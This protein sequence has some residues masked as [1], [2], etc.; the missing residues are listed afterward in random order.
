MAVNLSPVAGAAAQFFDNS[1]QVLTGGKLYTYDAGTTTPAPTYTSSSGV[2]AQPNP[3][4]LNAAGRVPDS[5]E[6]WLSDSVSYKFVLKDANDVLIGTYD[7][8]VG[9]NS[10][11]V[12]FT[13]EEETQT[14]TQGQT[15]FTLATLTYQPATNNLLVFV[16]GS[17]QVIGTNFIETSS[18]VITFIDG[19]NV[20]DIVDFCTATPINTSVMTAAQVS[21]NEGGAGAVTRTVQSKLQ[22]SVSV[23]DF[24]AICDGTTDDTVAVQKA[25]TY[26]VTNNTNLVVPGTCLLTA[27]ININRAVDVPNTYFYISGVAG[28]TTQAGFKTNTAINLFSSTL[29]PVANAPV[30][31]MIVFKDLAIQSS[32]SS[33]AAYV[34]AGNKFLRTK[35]ENC[36]FNGIKCLTTTNYVQSIYFFNCTMRIFSGIFFNCTSTC[37][38]VKFMGNLVENGGQC[39]LLGSSTANQ[40]PNGCCFIGNTIEGMTGSAIQYGSAA[41]LSIIG[42]YF[43][44]NGKDIDGATIGGT[45]RGIAITGNFYSHGPYSDYGVMWGTCS[46]A[47]SMGNLGLG[48]INNL[49][50]NSQVAINDAS[51]NSNVSNYD[52]IS[53]SGYGQATWSPVFRGTITANYTYTVTSANFTRNGEQVTYMFKGTMTSTAT[54]A[55]EQFYIPSGLPWNDFEAGDLVGQVQ[56]VDAGGTVY[57]SPL[58]T[59]TTTSIQ[60]TGLVIPSNASGNVFTVRGQFSVLSNQIIG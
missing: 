30:T 46:G 28:S 35:F 38:D 32:N 57:S 40:G 16:N 8:L 21:Y 54:N 5:G 31:Q 13:G 55:S 36:A 45:S 29:T 50:A 27:S 4:I 60:S 42:N 53:N 19:L 39:A 10:N 34:L 12:N 11:F 33:L 26:C 52:A 47:V 43:E 9:I 23:M 17:K 59:L 18:T 20:G 41:G 56:I 6:I 3:I 14:A 1:G 49:S 51:V 44:S 48:N 25:V 7:N 22:E 15:V 37:Y 2:T 24:G 58:I